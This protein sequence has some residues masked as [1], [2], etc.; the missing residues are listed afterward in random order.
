MGGI[1]TDYSTRFGK[2]EKR[3]EHKFKKGQ[4]V[5]I[6]YMVDDEEETYPVL[7]GKIRSI[8][9]Y[10]EVVDIDTEMQGVLMRQPSLPFD[11]NTECETHTLIFLCPEDAENYRRTLL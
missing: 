8:S 7:K 5:W 1:M 3:E 11:P 6:V 4:T 2:E 10:D 9:L